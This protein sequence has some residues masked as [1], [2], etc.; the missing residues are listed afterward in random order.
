MWFHSVL[1][2]FSSGLT[3]TRRARRPQRP[4]SSRPCLEALEGRNAP[5]AMNVSNI[6][7]TKHDTLAEYGS[8]GGTGKVRFLDALTTPPIKQTPGP[9]G[10]HPSM[11]DAAV[12]GADN[13]AKWFLGQ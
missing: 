10:P 12:T 4:L 8:G 11:T 9:P 1:A 3:R 5:S 13:V 2:A 7:K 6:M